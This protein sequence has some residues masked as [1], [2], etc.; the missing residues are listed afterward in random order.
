MVDTPSFSYTRDQIIRRALRQVGAI[1]AGETP[2]A[3]EVSDAS[4]ALNAM[5][6]QWQATGLHIWKE[7]E[8]TLFLQP[9]IYNY[10]LG[11]PNGMGDYSSDYSSDYNIGS[12]GI[13]NVC[14]TN[15]YR[16]L[17]VG[18]GG[19]AAGAQAIPV[20]T[21][22]GIVVGDNFGVMMSNNQLFWSI[23]TSVVVTLSGIVV[24]I[25]QILP[26]S[27]NGGA[28]AYDYS[29]LS[30]S[31]TSSC[32]IYRPLRILNV[33]RM[34]LS[35]LIETMVTPMARLDYRNMPNKSNT[36]VVTQWYYDPQLVTGQF[37]AWP[38]PVDSLSVLNFTYMEPIYDFGSAA[39]G[40]DFPQEWINALV[41]NLAEEI[42]LEYDVGGERAARIEAKA[43]QTL[44]LVSGFDRE[45]ESYFLG[46]NFDQTGR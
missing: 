35:S 10:G 44:D 18:S 6:A 11:D 23:V 37:W 13:G 28:S 42:K 32:S 36:G 30:S 5:V 33:R 3:Q 26:N 8:A 4:D 7:K 39:D 24:N 25:N 2:G 40:P 38:N 27:V 45:P 41:W 14:P 12:I 9:G 31:I 1:A 29:Q 17:T 34:L 46:V 21:A 16:V 20:T 22:G 15:S 43:A 19:V